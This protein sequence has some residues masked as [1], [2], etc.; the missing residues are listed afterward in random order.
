[1]KGWNSLRKIHDLDEKFIYVCIALFAM[2]F[3]LNNFLS[4]KYFYLYILL[5]NISILYGRIIQW[6]QYTYVL[7]KLSMIFLWDYECAIYNLPSCRSPRDTSFFSPFG[8]LFYAT[9][10][11]P[12]ARFARARKV[13]KSNYTVFP[14][15]HSRIFNSSVPWR[16]EGTWL[17]T[18]A[19]ALMLSWIIWTTLA[20]CR[21]DFFLISQQH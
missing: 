3:S 9:W 10:L 15:A 2:Y 18:A 1:M 21:C 7:H 19:C 17:R 5:L 20:A 14:D 4:Y 13:G 12:S 6:K 11:D 16:T 8:I